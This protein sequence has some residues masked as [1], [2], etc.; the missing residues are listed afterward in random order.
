M[1]HPDGWRCREAAVHLEGL[2]G[3]GG[4]GRVWSPALRRSQSTGSSLG[5]CAHGLTHVPALPSLLEGT[6]ELQPHTRS[7]PQMTWGPCGLELCSPVHKE[8]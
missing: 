4:A 3:F 8:G 6:N 1:V 2:G 5:S 7:W